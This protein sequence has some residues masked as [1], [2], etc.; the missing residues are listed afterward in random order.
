MSRSG[1]AILARM[2][3]LIDQYESGVI[4]LGRLVDE[5]GSMYDALGPGEQ[6]DERPWLDAF[7]P[8]DRLG[9]G[10]TGRDRSEIQVRVAR[11]LDALRLLIA[12][13]RS[14]AGSVGA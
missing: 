14:A 10:G 8:I 6:P 7:I 5:L 12:S 1:Q 4:D 3:E 9:S 13:S 11:S 2:A